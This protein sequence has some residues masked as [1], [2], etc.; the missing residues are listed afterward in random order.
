MCWIIVAI[1]LVGVL[2]NARGKWQGFLFWLI[3]NAYWCYRNLVINQYAQAFV[4]V[5]FWG[6]SVYGIF[7]WRKQ[8]K[9]HQQAVGQAKTDTRA[10]SNKQTA[11]L[12]S[13]NYALSSFIK[14]LPTKYQPKRMKFKTTKQKGKNYGKSKNQGKSDS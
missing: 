13:K 5:I 2:L 8:Q 11:I 1:A 12:L 4:F 3:S 9:A 10:R 7:C 6:M 14:S